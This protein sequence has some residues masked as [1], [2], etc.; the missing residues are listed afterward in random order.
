MKK[1][2]P[3]NNYEIF[4]VLE[5]EDGLPAAAAA[6]SCNKRQQRQLQQRQRCAGITPLSLRIIHAEEQNTTCFIYRTAAA[7]RRVRVPLPR[8][9]TIWTMIEIVVS[10]PSSHRHTIQT[11]PK[12]MSTTDVELSSSAVWV[13][14]LSLLQ[15]QP[16]EKV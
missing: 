3:H 4:H 5:D 16:L 15:Q 12:I 10:Y 13:C 7:M 8:R 6:D 11:D 1:T 9:C 14:A 2:G